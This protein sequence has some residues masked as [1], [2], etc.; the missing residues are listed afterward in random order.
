VDIIEGSKQVVKH[1]HA[2]TPPAVNPTK[3]G[4][5]FDGWD[6]DYTNITWHTDIHPK[7]KNEAQQS[8]QY[9]VRFLDANGGDYA[10]YWV[11]PG[12]DSAWPRTPP[13]KEGYDFDGWE[14]DYTNVTRDIVITP[15]WKRNEQS[16]KQYVVTFIDGFGAALS[17]QLVESG[18]SAKP[19]SNPTRN[20]Y[21]FD[22]WSGS[23]TNVTG[24]RNI[25][26]KWKE[27]GTGETGGTGGTGGGTGG[28]GETGGTGGNSFV[29]TWTGSG[30][31]EI[32]FKS[33]STVYA[34]WM[35]EGTYAYTG[36]KVTVTFGSKSQTL[37]IS[38]NKFTLDGITF[39]K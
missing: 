31:R 32:I 2:A 8:A 29:G 36:N 39:S 12:E 6:L 26:A 24:D 35:G 27:E 1:G 17:T 18:Q 37:T 34:N 33:D 38:G 13:A 3:D 7:W 23:Y 22:G 28:T 5:I 19:P 25:T 30:G 14:G 10:T 16:I 15:K 4:Y 20:G 9:L 11:D 21:T